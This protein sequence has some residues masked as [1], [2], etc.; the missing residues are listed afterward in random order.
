MKTLDLWRAQ[1]LSDVGLRYISANCHYLV[2]LDVGWWYV[3]SFVLFSSN[4]RYLECLAN[5]L[6]MKDE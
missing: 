2:G 1:G 5:G 3:E 6:G 4:S